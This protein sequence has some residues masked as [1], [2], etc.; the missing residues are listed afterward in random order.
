MVSLTPM[1]PLYDAI[2]MI[3]SH[4]QAPFHERVFT[5]LDMIFEGSRYALELFGREGEYALE[6]NLPFHECPQSDMLVRTEELVKQQ[7]PMFERL[8]AGETQPM[9][10]SDFITMRQLRRLDLYHE[11]FQ[12]LYIRHQIGIPIQSPLVLGGLTINRDRRDYRAEDLALAAVLAPQ[13]ATAF[14]VDL[15]FRK[16]AKSS[17]LK[18][19][20]DYTH[21]R[22]LGLSRREAEIM[23]WIIEA[24]RDRE[25]AIILGISVRTVQQHVRAILE[26]LHVENRLAAVRLVLKIP[27][28]AAPTGPLLAE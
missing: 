22:H 4:G 17:Q 3:H 27:G 25:I 6:S 10:L 26:K 18:A 8:A 16:L 15:L 5:A 9:R 20:P 23:I 14:E 28:A 21:L 12:Q 24:K 19:P 7:S 1:R 11:I 2:R 13:I